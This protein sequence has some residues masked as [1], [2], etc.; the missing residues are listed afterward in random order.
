MKSVKKLGECQG[1]SVA[2][3]EQHYSKLTGYACRGEIGL[4]FIKMLK[5][6]YVQGA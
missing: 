5:D 4:K 1:I 3:L 6:L 2:M